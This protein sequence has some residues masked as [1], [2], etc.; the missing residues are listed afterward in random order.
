MHHFSL[1]SVSSIKSLLLWNN[2]FSLSCLVIIITLSPNFCHQNNII[3]IMTCETA[4]NDSMSMY[5]QDSFTI[6]NVKSCHAGEVCVN[7][8]IVWVKY[9]SHTL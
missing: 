3:I 7:C 4:S 9:C 1:S 8:V 5:V 2:T 6:A